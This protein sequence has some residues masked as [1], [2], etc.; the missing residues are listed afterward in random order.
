MKYILALA[1]LAGCGASELPTTGTTTWSA[2]LG[3]WEAP[4]CQGAI[5]LKGSPS[6]DF[7]GQTDFSGSWS[8]GSYGTQASGNLT[9]DGRVF[10]DLETAPGYLNRMRGTLAA[11]DAISG[12]ILIDGQQVPFAAYRQ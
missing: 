9:P 11:P 2:T 8:C 4:T 1:F 3:N 5:T 7:A 10:L 12:D 6:A